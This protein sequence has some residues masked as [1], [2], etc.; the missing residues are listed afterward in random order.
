MKLRD[1]IT[2]KKFW[3][4]VTAIVAAFA[5]YFLTACSA[6]HYVT[7]SASSFRSGD[8]TTT[9]IRYEQ[10]GGFKKR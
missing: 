4:L 9:I 2:S 10:L 8:T 7:Q 3:T 5:A 1:V 6:S